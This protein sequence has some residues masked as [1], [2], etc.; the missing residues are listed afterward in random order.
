MKE[1]TITVEY[2][3]GSLG[4]V[5]AKTFTDE[6]KAQDYYTDVLVRYPE[7]KVEKIIN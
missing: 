7:A 6:A 4:G 5:I 3:R 1:I 2:I